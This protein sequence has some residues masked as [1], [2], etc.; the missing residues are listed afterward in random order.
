MNKLVVASTALL[1]LAA[2]QPV[3][4]EPTR[5]QSVMNQNALYETTLRFFLHPTCLDWADVALAR[6]GEHL[7]S[8]H[9]P[10]S[11]ASLLQLHNQALG[12]L[13]FKLSAEALFET[14]QG[15][16]SWMNS[17]DQDCTSPS[18]SLGSA[19]PNAGSARFATSYS[20]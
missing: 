10:E 9:E 19:T 3:L 16:A 7:S 20:Q 14:F 6:P 5:P 13:G 18:R 2:L 17:A 4:A 11:F 15:E 12:A 1:S 8:D